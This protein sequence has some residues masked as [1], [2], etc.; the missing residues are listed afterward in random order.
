MGKMGRAWGLVNGCIA[1]GW[2]KGMLGL[3]PCMGCG[4]DLVYAVKRFVDF[5]FGHVQLL[6]FVVVMV[7]P[8]SFGHLDSVK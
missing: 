6:M 7:R 2:V 3:H 5:N 1:G 8:N 4:R